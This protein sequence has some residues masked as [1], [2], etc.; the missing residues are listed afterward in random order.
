VVLWIDDRQHS[1]GEAKAVGRR[2][3]RGVLTRPSRDKSRLCRAKGRLEYNVKLADPT[4][5]LYFAKIEVEYCV[6]VGPGRVNEWSRV[7]WCKVAATHKNYP[8]LG[9]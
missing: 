6:S 1:Q 3:G 7:E 4:R 5:L 8:G 9:M 2:C